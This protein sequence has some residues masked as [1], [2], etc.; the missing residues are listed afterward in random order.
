[1]ELYRRMA[2][3]AAKRCEAFCEEEEEEE[4]EEEKEK[5]KEKEGVEGTQEKKEKKKN[6][7][8]F[9]FSGAR[10][11]ELRRQGNHQQQGPRAGIEVLR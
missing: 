4:E 6:E 7:S 5:E 8:A 11:N 9:R 3:V 2:A 10:T 1:M